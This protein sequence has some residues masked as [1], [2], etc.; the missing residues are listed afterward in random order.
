MTGTFPA[1][2][3]AGIKKAGTDSPPTENNVVKNAGDPA[4]NI[5]AGSYAI[6][7]ISQSG[8]TFYAPMQGRPGSK[9]TAKSASPLYPTSSVKIATTFLPTPKQTTTMTLSMTFSTDSHAHTVGFPT[10]RLGLKIETN[11]FAR[12]HL[13]PCQKMTCRN[14]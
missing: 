6:P 10:R 8:L 1:N 11:E 13:P 7:Y 12:P 2:V 14:I 9:I 3:L 4:A 5:P